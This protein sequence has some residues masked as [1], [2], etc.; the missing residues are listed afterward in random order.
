MKIDLLVTNVIWASTHLI[1]NA[2]TV[3]QKIHCVWIAMRKGAL[4]AWMAFLFP[5]ESV[6]HANSSQA[7]S[8]VSVQQK[9]AALSVNQATT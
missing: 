4:D 5:Q 8:K 1:A 2:L 3:K 7:V 6:P 9:L